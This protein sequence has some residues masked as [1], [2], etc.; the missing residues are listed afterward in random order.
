MNPPCYCDAASAHARNLANAAAHSARACSFVV[1][2]DAARLAQ[3]PSCSTVRGR[4]GDRGTGTPS[5]HAAGVSGGSD[6]RRGA[7]CCAGRGE[8]DARSIATMAIRRIIVGLAA[9]RCSRA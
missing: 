6:G 9:A 4:D 5:A 2:A 8:H 7:N 1:A 3:W